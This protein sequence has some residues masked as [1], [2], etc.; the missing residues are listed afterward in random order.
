MRC[1][2]VALVALA[3]CDKVLLREREFFDAPPP[4]ECWSALHRESDHDND[5]RV[6]GCDN[7]PLVANDEQRDLDA[8]QIGDVC[9]DD[10]TVRHRTAYFNGF[11]DPATLSDL[12]IISGDW[13]ITN[14]YLNQANA[15]IRTVLVLPGV[16]TDARILVLVGAISVPTVTATIA[17]PAVSVTNPGIDAQEAGLACQGIRNPAT[18]GQ[19]RLTRIGPGADTVMEN[20]ALGVQLFIALSAAASTT[21]LPTCTAS[22]GEL[23]LT[24]A[25]TQVGPR[26][27]EVTL[28]TN[29]ATARFLAVHLILAE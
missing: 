12:R 3:G 17:G 19:V 25:L 29:R 18:G 6:D 10:S 21:G 15:A 23:S 4:G 5:G 27:G 13:S 20:I 24:A 26:T 7:C 2:L 11:E 22:N 14:G 16:Y 9:D 28:V 1:A 8:D